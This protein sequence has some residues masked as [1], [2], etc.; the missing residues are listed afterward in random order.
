MTEQEIRKNKP[1]GA[2]HWNPNNA[3]AVYYK[4]NDGK[5]KFWV[6]KHQLWY[7]SCVGMDESKILKPL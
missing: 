7:G 4:I 6:D 1:D 3:K 5:I 2:T